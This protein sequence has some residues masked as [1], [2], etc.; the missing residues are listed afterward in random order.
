MSAAENL[1]TVV[2]LI[3]DWDRNGRM[4]SMSVV[5]LCRSALESSSRAVWLLSPEERTER[6]SRA[7]RMMKAEVLGQKKFLTKRVAA[8]ESLRSG[9]NAELTGLRSDL[10][11]AIDVLDDLDQASGAPTIEQQIELASAWVDVTAVNPQ[12]TPMA[13]QAKSMYSIASGFAHGYTW[14]TRHM[15]G[16]ADLFNVTADFLYVATTMLSA[17]VIL[18]E[19]QSATTED[20]ISDL[21]PAHLR[22]TA[23]EFH[24]RYSRPE[25]DPL[26]PEQAAATTQQL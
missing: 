2:R 15:Q 14:T 22:D 17:A 23:R 19:T 7:T 3:D 6:R 20:D 25:A 11:H 12:H 26:R 16:A 5:T 24:H 13:E 4:R 8:L 9:D 10:A 18:L 21:C 1:T